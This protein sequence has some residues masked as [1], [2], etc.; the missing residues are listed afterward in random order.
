[1][2]KNQFSLHYL[3]FKK[4]LKHL[5]YIVS[6]LVYFLFYAREAILFGHVHIR[7]KAQGILPELKWWICNVKN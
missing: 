2:I 1:M 5:Q 3:S 6:T 4:Y 7:A